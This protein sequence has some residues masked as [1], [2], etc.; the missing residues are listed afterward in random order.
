V[1]G[2]NAQEVHLSSRD[3]AGLNAPRQFLPGVDNP[4]AATIVEVGLGAPVDVPDFV[5]SSDVP[6][7]TIRGRAVT[8]A[9]APAAGA[10]I[11]V[12]AESTS[13]PI[14]GAPAI[15]DADGRFSIAVLAGLRCALTAEWPTPT[16]EKP[17]TFDVGTSTP[18]SATE[19]LAPFELI[20]RPVPPARP[21]RQ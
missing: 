3:A 17:W 15:S 13:L 8:P 4:A 1:I 12:T 14:G 16:K 5:W 7:V 11:Y 21:P 18:F 9:G 6:V 10:K 2:S 19:D 20:V